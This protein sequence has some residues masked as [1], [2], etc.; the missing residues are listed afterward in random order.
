MPGSPDALQRGHRAR[1]AGDP[2]QALACYREA[3]T[4]DPHSAEAQGAFGLMLLRAGEVDAAA[5]PLQQAVALAP[6]QPAFRMNLAEFHARRG[7][8]ASALALVE[9][10]A[11]AQ[12]DAWW[13][14]ER[15]GEL[16][17]AQR[18]FGAARTAFARALALRPADP[19]ILYKLARA[20]CDCGHPAAAEPLLREADAR[21]PGHASVMGLQAELLAARAGWS[22]LEAH[23]RRWLALSPGHGM[24]LRWLSRAQWESGFLQD[25]LDNWQAALR[26]G[27]RDVAGLATLARLALLA[28][29]T[30]VAAAA[31]D[32]AETREPGAVALLQ[33]RAVLA[34][35]RGEVDV[36]EHCARRA[37]AQDPQDVSAWKTL[38]QL[39]GGRLAAAEV[40]AL[41]GL[42]QSGALDD[43]DRAS[44]G[45]ALGDCL[46]AAGRYAEAFDA[47]AQANALQA[48]RGAREG[49]AYSA[50]VREREADTVIA[51]F[52]SQHE[53]AGIPPAPLRPVFIVGMPRSGTTL[54]ESVLAGHPAVLPCGE[55][56]AMRSIMRECMALGREPRVDELARWREEYFRGISASGARQVLVDKN[57][58]NA[59]A[60]G[61]IVR[62][63]PEACV[64]HLVRDAD[65]TALSI[66]RNEFPKFASFS[67]RLEDIAHYRSQVERLMRHWDA[68]LPGRV[69]L[70]RHEELVAD[71]DR[72][73]PAVL[74]HCGLAWDEG[75]RD[76]ARPGRA[77]ATLST[78]QVRQPL[79]SVRGR[80]AHYREF[81]P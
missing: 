52:S 34:M 25:A 47:W 37:L 33:G 29:D 4:A 7:D 77:I 67:N 73:A 59:D 15:L 16:Q 43:R 13:A 24:A 68:V 49:L 40:E 41:R 72:L 63:F 17:A 66:F 69:L 19:A 48:A 18:E 61:L 65:E 14:W 21:A 30:D 56:Q 57:P 2:G 70:L 58:W 8:V 80:A 46:D 39:R 3:V 5:S 22:A 12:P 42:A 1:Q 53:D 31:L 78:V 23:A 36:A 74:A 45:F 79:G 27:P 76:F 62:L 50:A 60:V 64:L 32:E 28:L 10:I 35:Y 81:L 20:E 6:A 11:A 26:A 71:F 38:V 75:C 55:R 54:L 9:P 44:A 51:A